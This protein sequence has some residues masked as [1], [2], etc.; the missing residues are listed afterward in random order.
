MKYALFA[1]ILKPKLDTREESN[2][3]SFAS[4]AEGIVMQS[5][6]AVELNQGTYQLPLAAG[7]SHLSNLVRCANDWSVECRV[8]FFESEPAWVVTPA[9]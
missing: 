2:W 9:K 7:L 6:G 5:A 3:R 1:A 8:L 4:T